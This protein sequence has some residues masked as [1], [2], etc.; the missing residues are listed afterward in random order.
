M[1]S[2]ILKVLTLSSLS[3]LLTACAGDYAFNS[4]LD[5]KAINEYFKVGDVTVYEENNLPKGNYAIIG[6]A[7]GEVC[8]EQSNDAPASIQDARTKARK[9]AA[10]MGANGI[11]I[12]QC[13]IIE[14][15]D[16]ACVSRSLCIGQAI[17]HEQE[18]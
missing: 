5:P 11:I 13:L 16:K 1:F 3:L 15:Q 10:D 8:Q 9:K 12:K 6:L 14:E 4:N 7:E 18:K 2:P 17:K